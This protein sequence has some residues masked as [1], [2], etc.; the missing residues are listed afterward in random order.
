MGAHKIALV[1]HNI[2]DGYDFYRARL[3]PNT[4]FCFAVIASAL[5][6]H[7]MTVPNPPV[8]FC[9]SLFW[10]LL[11]CTWSWHGI[12]QNSTRFAIENAIEVVVSQT[13]PYAKTLQQP[14]KFKSQSYNS[15]CKFCFNTTYGFTGPGLWRRCSSPSC[16]T[17]SQVMRKKNDS[18]FFLRR[19]YCC[20]FCIFCVCI[21]SPEPKSIQT[22]SNTSAQMAQEN[23]TPGLEQALSTKTFFQAD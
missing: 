21:F 13:L 2:H 10:I 11:I 12:T 8:L 3:S 1:L 14:S 22:R 15:A 23:Q 18:I 20:R 19:K 5:V 17:T 9:K 4:R 6:E 16:R 7:V